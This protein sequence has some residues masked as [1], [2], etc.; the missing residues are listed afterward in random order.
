MAGTSRVNREVYARFC[1]RLVVKFHRPTRQVMSNTPLVQHLFELS[2]H[3]LPFHAALA[4]HFI[5][6]MTVP[7]HRS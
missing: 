5:G 7:K 6:K 4:C 1:G 2:R 3:R